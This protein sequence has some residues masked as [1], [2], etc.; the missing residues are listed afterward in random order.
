MHR[1]FSERLISQVC[2][3]FVQ[4]SLADFG[5]AFKRGNEPT[6]MNIIVPVLVEMAEVRP[7]EAVQPPTPNSLRTLPS[8]PTCRG[9]P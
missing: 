7:A 5:V 4:L 8:S 6:V 1:N 3:E 9:R 2:K